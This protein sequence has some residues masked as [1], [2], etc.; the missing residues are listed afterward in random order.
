MI[1]AAASTV[2]EGG[3]DSE[4]VDIFKTLAAMQTNPSRE[5]AL[6]GDRDV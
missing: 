5:E 3:R 4:A 1:G 2:A 6:Q